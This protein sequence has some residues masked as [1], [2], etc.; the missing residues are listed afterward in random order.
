MK[1]GVENKMSDKGI[2]SNQEQDQLVKLFDDIKLDLTVTDFPTRT[3]RLEAVN[4]MAKVL[5]IHGWLCIEDPEIT[6]LPSKSQREENNV[7]RN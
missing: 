5:K 7:K 3:N 4:N 6:E 1:E 2:L